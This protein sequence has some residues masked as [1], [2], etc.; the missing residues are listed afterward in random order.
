MDEDHVPKAADGGPVPRSWIYAATVGPEG[1]MYAHGVG[2][3]PNVDS[4]DV[5]RAVGML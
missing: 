3:L 1:C 4:V 5:P 2:L